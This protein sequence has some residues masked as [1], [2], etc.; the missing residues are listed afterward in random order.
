VLELR[1]AHSGFDVATHLD[2]CHALELDAIFKRG[3]P[4]WSAD[5]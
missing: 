2:D 4:S 3:M 5:E 1:R